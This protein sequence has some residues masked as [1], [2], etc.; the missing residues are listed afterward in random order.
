M[1][2]FTQDPKQIQMFALRE[3]CKKIIHMYGENTVAADLAVNVLNNVLTQYENDIKKVDSLKEPLKLRIAFYIAQYGNWLDQLIGYFTESPYSHCELIYP[4]TYT[5]LKNKPSLCYS[6]SPRDGGV[7]SKLISLNK[8]HWHVYDIE[9]ENEEKLTELTKQIQNYFFKHVGQS[10]DYLGAIGSA[11]KI[12]LYS[13]N[14]KFCSLACAQA[15]K[16]K[17]FNLSPADLFTYLCEQQLID[18]NKLTIYPSE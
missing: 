4:S 10:Y 14:K 11:L 17:D 18:P 16:L 5:D 8:K 9:I 6:S 1:S 3:Q 15:L 13:K 7:R 2:H 12:P